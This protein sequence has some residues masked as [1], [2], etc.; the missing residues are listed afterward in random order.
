[1]AT[2][3]KLAY[4]KALADNPKL[5]SNVFSRMM[6]KRKIRKEYAKA[7]REAKKA[8]HRTKKAG[9]FIVRTAKA[10]GKVVLRNPKTMIVLSIIGFLVIIMMG[11]FVSVK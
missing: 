7:A 8:A 3:P 5:K 11:L 10:I 4:Q 6:Q 9:S 2:R 1:M